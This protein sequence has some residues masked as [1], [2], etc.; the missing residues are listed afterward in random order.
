MKGVIDS[1]FSERLNIRCGIVLYPNNSNREESGE[2]IKI[3]KNVNKHWKFVLTISFEEQLKLLQSG[4][5]FYNFNTC[6]KMQ[7]IVLGWHKNADVL[8]SE[9]SFRKGQECVF[10]LL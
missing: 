9:V 4:F 2:I 10:S 7:A 5:L 3:T 6:G 8:L 1:F